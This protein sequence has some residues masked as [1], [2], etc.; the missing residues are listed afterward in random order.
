MVTK[1][2]EQ[3][4][5]LTLKVT[6]LKGALVSSQRSTAEA[7]K[8]LRL[9]DF[10]VKELESNFHR[11]GS[12]AVMETMR[13][14]RLSAQ[15]Q[16]AQAEAAT[17]KAESEQLQGSRQRLETELRQVE[18]CRD[19]LSARCKRLTSEL[20]R[21]KEPLYADAMN[22]EDAAIRMTQAFTEQ[23]SNLSFRAP[24]GGVTYLRLLEIAKGNIEARITGEVQK[25]T[26]NKKRGG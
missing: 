22:H 19:E 25:A 3:L 12:M 21:A 17:A 2:E 7:R 24:N 5:E 11:L 1:N 13:H 8:E 10:H 16:A 26:G 15:L 20:K 9:A 14:A 18:G 6:D 23:L 4:R